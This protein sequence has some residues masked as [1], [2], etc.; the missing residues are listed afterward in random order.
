MSTPHRKGIGNIVAPPR[1]LLF[2]AATLGAGWLLLPRLGL[3]FGVMLAFDVGAAVFLLSVIPLLGHRASGMRE[4]ACRNDANRPVLLLITVMVGVAVFAAIA[5]E[6]MSGI[7]SNPWALPAILGTLALSWTFSNTIYALHYAHLFYTAG[8][9][10]ADQGGLQ[11]PE[12]KEPD[13]WD[14]LYFAV[15]LGMT[16]QTSDVTISSR[17]LRRVVTAHCLAAFVFNLGILAFTINVLGG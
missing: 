2:L 3:H 5:S 16:F 6:L 8:R 7:K 9:G 10:G 12:T 13:Y 14:F 1:F 17:Q 4:S 15:C 11:F